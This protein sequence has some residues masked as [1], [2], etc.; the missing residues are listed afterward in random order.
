MEEKKKIS[1]GGFPLSTPS[2]SF[3]FVVEIVVVIIVVIV[4]VVVVVVIVIVVMASF[5]K[6]LI[7]VYRAAHEKQHSIF[8]C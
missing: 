4:I 5:C 3:V 6:D 2:F 7:K 8:F 1:R